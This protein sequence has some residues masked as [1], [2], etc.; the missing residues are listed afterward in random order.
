MEGSA[1]A[2]RTR[3]PRRRALLVLAVAA[4]VVVAGF[5]VWWEFVR[6]RSIAE[7]FA[8]DHFQPGT[9]VIVQGTITRIYWENTT[10]GPRVALQLD[11]RRECSA[12]DLVTGPAAG[13]VFGDPS[14]TYSIGQPFQTT[15]HFQSYT[16]NGDPAVTAPELA[17]PFP[18]GF[19]ALR[20]LADSVSRIQ[21]ILLVYNGSDVGGWQEYRVFTRNGDAYNLSALPVTLQRSDRLVGTTPRF[22]AGTALDSTTSW[23]V[24]LTVLMYGAVGEA[25]SLLYPVIDRMA[26]MLD[27]SSANG[28]LRFI[29][30]NANRM[31]DN[32]DRLDVRLPPTASSTSWETYLLR[33]GMPFDS[34]W[35]YVASEHILLNGPAGPLEVLPS[36]E[37]PMVDLAYAGTR[38]GPPLESSVQ[39]ASIRIGRPL[40][41]AAVRYALSARTVGS[42]S[43]IMGNLTSLPETTVDGVTLSFNDTNGDNLLDAG[44]RFTVAGAANQTHLNLFVFGP[45][46]GGGEIDW[47]VGFGPIW[48]SVPFPTFTIQGSGPWLI[49]AD[50]PSWSPELALNRTVRATLYE[51]YSAVVTNMTLADGTPATFAGGSLTFTDADRDGYLSTGDYFTLRGNPGARYRLEVTCFFGGQTLAELFIPGP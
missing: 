36:S 2:A 5:V 25:P 26:S 48:R 10:Y 12:T 42:H 41:L 43:S 46:G 51:N 24:L 22:P 44:D 9:T 50:V 15:L 40:P 20:S 16:I 11:G 47:I 1:P 14:V 49:Q 23:D 35:S 3:V 28:S 13:Q 32:G 30:A 27:G 45:A 21:G 39:V 31:L 17:C 7:V 37:L 29:D 33:I 34:N 8:F 18:S 38:S 4:I 6:P 19:T